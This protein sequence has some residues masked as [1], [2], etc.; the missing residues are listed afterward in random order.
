MTDWI[1]IQGPHTAEFGKWLTNYLKSIPRYKDYFVCYD[2]GD[3]RT[4][5]N[6]V[7]I[8][9]FF[10]KSV[11]NENRLSDVDVIVANHEK[12][13]IVLI[14]IEETAS[15]PQK[16][17]GSVFAVLMCNRFA[18]KLNNE[19]LYFQTS[20]NTK[21]VVAGI[22]P[23]E[24]RLRKINKVISP[25]IKQFAAPANSIRPENVAFEFAM[26]MPSTIE[27]LKEKIKELFPY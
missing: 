13:I 7:E 22:L 14:E 24:R 10:G 25:R 8:K 12:K 11:N 27:V 20:P 26:D 2:H 17:I 4:Q 3:A 18:I 16:Y 15:P 23:T 5:P 21:F 1:P 6:V 9:G 19:Q